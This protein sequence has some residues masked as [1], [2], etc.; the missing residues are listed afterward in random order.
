M[1]S[2]HNLGRGTC[3]VVLT[4][5]LVLALC[6]VAGAQIKLKVSHQFAEGDVRDQLVKV[7]AERVTN[8]LGKQVEF[9]VY[10]ASSL[11][12]PKE[13]W[14]AMRQGTLDMS[15]FPLDYAAGKVPE[16][17][18]TL[19]PCSVVSLQQAMS[20]QQKPIGQR[21]SKILESNGAKILVWAW[22]EGGIGSSVRQVRLPDEAKGLKMRAAGK[23]FEYMLKEAGASITS[24]PSSEIYH[25]LSTG[26]L[27]SCLT[28]SSSFVSYRLYEQLKFM[29]VPKDY[30]IWYMAE[31]LVIS[32][33]TWER[34]KPEQRKV[35]QDVGDEMARDWVV[36]NFSKDTQT[37]IDEFTKAGVQLH[38]MTKEEFQQWQDFAKKTAWK[39][40]EET[41]KDGKEILDLAVQA[42]Q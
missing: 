14:D 12:K 39:N 34:L 1:L 37:L 42:M 6:T 36:P 8:K 16:L 17:S 30:A 26:V 20:W 25:A 32:L 29:N 38:Y 41:V 5:I 3:G 24:M 4:T 10:P 7:F 33:K 31:P 40:Y 23:K 27:D 28:S 15:V 35:F 11:F 19:L 13:Q 21:L 18:I 2:D 22:L 9:R